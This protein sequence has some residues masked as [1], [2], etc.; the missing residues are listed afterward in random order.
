MKRNGI[1]PSDL[2]FK[3]M[4]LQ[5][6]NERLRFQAVSVSDVEK[7]I[8]ENRSMKLEIQK[9]HHSQSVQDGASTK[10]D[11]VKAEGMV[12]LTLENFTSNDFD[13]ASSILRSMIVIDEGSATN[14][15]QNVFVSRRNNIPRPGGQAFKNGG[16]M[17]VNSV[18]SFPKTEVPI[19]VKGRNN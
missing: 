4:K 7:L 18:N 8:A 13:S 2:H 10:S 1:N 16:M 6:E 17:I 12:A 11:P 3:M 19:R 15:S 14:V 9:L 5:E